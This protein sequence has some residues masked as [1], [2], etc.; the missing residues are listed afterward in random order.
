MMEVKRPLKHIPNILTV[1]RLFLVPIF[2]FLYFS[3]LPNAHFYALAVFI[4]AGVTDVLDGAIARRYNLVSVVGTVLDPLADK[5]M[6]LTALICLTVDGIM[7]VWAMGIM[8]V[9]ELF[10]ITGG[11]IMYFRKEKSVIPANKFGKLATI[12]FSLAVFLM[13]VRPGTWYTMTVLIVALAS[14]LSAFTSYA[15]HYYHNV[16]L[17]RE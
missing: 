3:D 6:L 15:S 1:I 14:K 13:I 9:K 16:R 10:M 12:L 7:P 2:A 5:L 8:L 4:L 11:L 17:K